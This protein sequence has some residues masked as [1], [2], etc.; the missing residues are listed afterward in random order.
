MSFTYNG[1]GLSFASG[2]VMVTPLRNSVETVSDTVPPAAA[3]NSDS[4]S[5]QAVDATVVLLSLIVTA[6]FAFFVY[7]DYWKQ[8]E[9]SLPSVRARTSPCR[10]C[11]FFHSSSLL[12]CAV[13][14]T[15]VLTPEAEDCQDCEPTA[16]QKNRTR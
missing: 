8:T 11:R 6:G 1:N 9:S 13:H 16:N 7:L 3:P 12:K 5:P 4:L 15:R 14:P 2:K 10:N